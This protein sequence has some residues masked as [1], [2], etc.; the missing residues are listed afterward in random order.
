MYLYVELWKPRPGWDNLPCEQ[1]E[2]FL[3]QLAPNVQR[4]K[5]L[6]VELVGFTVCDEDTPAD[7]EYRYMAVWRMKNRGYV[8]MLEKAVREEGWANYFDITNA[9][10][11]ILPVDELV[12]DMIKA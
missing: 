3:S 7:A 6:E 1:R 9:R 10:G 12:G 4:M 5:E 11:R 2:E 8:H